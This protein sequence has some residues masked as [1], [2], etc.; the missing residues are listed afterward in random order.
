MRSPHCMSEIDDEAVLD[1]VDALVEQSLV[2]R[3]ADSP[4]FGLLETIREFALEQL[5][6]C[7]ESTLA[8][9]RHAAYFAALAEEAAG[10]LLGPLQ[11]AWRD[12]LS[13]DQDNLRAALRWSRN[14]ILRWR[15]RWLAR[16]GGIGTCM[17]ILLREPNGW[18]GRWSVLLT[19]ETDTMPGRIRRLACSFARRRIF[20]RQRRTSIR[21]LASAVRS[22][23]SLA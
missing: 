22:T 7:S 21:P 20:P 17:A 14:T 23:I 10:E 9:H 11:L 1:I 12:R 4:R 3:T 13:A 6:A 8:G 2:K 16:L 15:C 19:P 5:E 18:N